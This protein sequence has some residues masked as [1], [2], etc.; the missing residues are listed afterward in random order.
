MECKPESWTI[1]ERMMATFKGEKPDR[2]PF[3]DRLELWYKTHIRAGTMPEEFRDLSLTDIHRKVGMGRQ[4][5]V[6][7]HGQRLRGVEMI[8]HFQDEVLMRET[9]PVVEFFPRMS[10]LAVQDRTGITTFEMV[11]PAGTLRMQYE[12]L[13]Q[14]VA[15][16]SEAYIREYPIKNE[17][18]Y[19]IA[20]YILERIEFVSYRDLVLEEER[21][22]ADIGFIVPTVCRIPF[23]Q[24]LLEF[25]GDVNTFYALHDHP[26]KVE[27]LMEILDRNMCRDLE[28]LADVSNPYVEFTDN[29]HGLMTNP[30]LFTK[31]CLPQ[32]QRYASIIHAQGKKMGSHT[33]GDMKPLLHLLP[34][35]GL[36]V[37]ESFSPAPLTPLT[38]DEAWAAWQP[39]PMI[40]GGIPSPIL[41]ERIAESEFREFVA[42][43]LETAGDRPII[44]GIGDQVMGNDLIERVRYIAEQI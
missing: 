16:G 15:M 40:W 38:F 36:D 31:D 24:V 18:D 33:D 32:Y 3:I 21:E 34:E 6:A 26:Q 37:A 4:K 27:R 11:T 35:C 30:R 7:A 14:M 42:Q 25:L 22:L 23:Q 44:L 8:V 41:E 12:M 43:V 19:P 20:E 9:D 17:T 29:L 5:F 1:R 39:A 13:D 10:D 2:M 28:H